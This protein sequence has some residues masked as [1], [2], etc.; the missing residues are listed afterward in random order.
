MFK[1]LLEI[2]QR[3]VL[4]SVGKT[5]TLFVHVNSPVFGGRLLLF[6]GSK[7]FENG[8]CF[9]H[10]HKSLYLETDNF[11]LCLQKI[12]KAKTSHFGLIKGSHV[13]I[14]TISNV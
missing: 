9:T 7:L 13:C 14:F 4:I 1:D 6:Q 2:S 8:G 12:A 10:F 11:F 3:P 5:M